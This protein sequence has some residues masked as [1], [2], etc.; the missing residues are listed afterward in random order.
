MTSLTAAAVALSLAH[1]AGAPSPATTTMEARVDVV[2]A[3]GDGVIGDQCP[4]QAE[5]LDEFEDEDGCPDP[6]NDDDSFLDADD[7]CPMA[8]ENW[9]GLD[10]EDGCPVRS[11]GVVIEPSA[12]LITQ[13]IHFEVGVAALRLTSAHL[14][15]EVA[16]VIIASPEVT[17][18][19]VR[20][21]TSPSEPQAD[22]GG[23]GGARVQSVLMYLLSRGVPVDRLE[24]RDLAATCLLGDEST[25]DGRASNRRV[26]FRIL[27]MDATGF[28][29]R[30]ECEY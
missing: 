16:Q 3:D 29:P 22:N 14:L 11:A 12:L 15:D 2:D 20:G 23:L 6:D 27:A 10:D 26:D 4:D 25:G 13:R 7:Q 24:A 8:P 17:R 28:V 18:V 9:N 1:C 5:D 21:H 30:G 19:E